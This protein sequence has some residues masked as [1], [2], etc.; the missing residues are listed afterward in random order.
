VVELLGRLQDVVELF[1]EVLRDIKNVD[2][3]AGSSR[4]ADGQ[5][6]RPGNEAAQISSR[7]TPMV[8]GTVSDTDIRQERESREDN[9]GL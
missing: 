8:L 5:V 9:F 7:V 1:A 6:Q 3:E 2:I 4:G